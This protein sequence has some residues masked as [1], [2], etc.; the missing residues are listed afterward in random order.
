MIG[1]Y[2]STS[3]RRANDY[4]PPKSISEQEV[5][6]IIKRCRGKGAAGPDGQISLRLFTHEYTSQE[7]RTGGSLFNEIQRGF[8]PCDGITENILF[9]RCLKES[10][11]DVTPIVPPQ[12]GH[13]INST[14]L[15]CK[16][17][18]ITP[19][20]KESAEKAFCRGTDE[21][22]SSFQ[23]KIDV[24]SPSEKEPAVDKN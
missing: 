14:R 12:G 16:E 17:L 19:A 6:A 13:H 24:K 5:L 22:R 8:V 10:L 3:L 18:A 20:T 7:N 11:S 2:H 9:A 15:I 23:R 21:V 1:A 4:Q